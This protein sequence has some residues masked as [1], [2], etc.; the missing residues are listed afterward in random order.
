MARAVDDL[1][2]VETV[3]RPV[4]HD[5]TCADAA[6]RRLDARLHQPLR[7]LDIERRAKLSAKTPNLDLQFG[8]PL[9]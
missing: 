1:G 3:D 9:R 5:H 8:V 7:A 4:E 6:H 2:L